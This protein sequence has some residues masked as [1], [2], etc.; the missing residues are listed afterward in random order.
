MLEFM[1]RY[2]VAAGGNL[3]GNSGMMGGCGGFLIKET[4]L[5][6]IDL[7][8]L[9]YFSCVSPHSLATAIGTGR[10]CVSH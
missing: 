2:S 6:L 4:K 1:V 10:S 9:S 8:Q 3:I 7:I 5:Q